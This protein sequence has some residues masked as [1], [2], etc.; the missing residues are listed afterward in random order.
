MRPSKSDKAKKPTATDLAGR[1]VCKEESEL[2][3]AK[4]RKSG[5]TKARVARL[6]HPT[7][8][9]LAGTPLCLE[10]NDHPIPLR[11]RPKR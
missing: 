9:D 10:E 2:P 6:A 1:P 3:S 11:K 5:K 8:E 4:G 7:A